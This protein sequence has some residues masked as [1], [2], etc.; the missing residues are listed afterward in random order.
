[1]H[2]HAG[3]TLVEL[4][5]T[6]AIVAVLLAVG[7]PGF[8]DVLAR[9]QVRTAMHLISTD[10]AMARNSAIM[11]ARATI[12]CPGN[13]L[14]GC[15]SDMD[16]NYGWI[17]FTDSD[18]DRQP[19]TDADLVR[20]TEAPAG[21]PSTIRLAAT[22]R[23]IRYQRNGLSAGTN[24]TVNVCHKDRLAGQVVVNNGGRT[25]ST[26]SAGNTPCPF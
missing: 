16:W 21:T 23:F 1:M 18:G 4:L 13:P 26:R 9:Q 5:T 19:N 2:T 11:R 17:V 3:F 20:V 7:L 8:A 10:L 6:L 14:T 12:V 25:R 15:R 24:L 22:R